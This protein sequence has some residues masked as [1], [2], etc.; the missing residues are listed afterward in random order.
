MDNSKFVSKLQKTDQVNRHNTD[1]GYN[2]VNVYM[3]DPRGQVRE[4]RVEVAR[5]LDKKIND[6]SLD[7]VNSPAI[8]AMHKLLAT[9]G[10]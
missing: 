10:F 6:P 9:D 1:I 2:E 3:S 5:L 8:T 7:L 4:L